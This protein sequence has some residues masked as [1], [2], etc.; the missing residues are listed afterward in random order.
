ML[1]GCLKPPIHL[2]GGKAFLSQ[3]LNGFIPGHTLYSEPFAGAAH[4]LF[5]KMPSKAEILNDSDGHLTS[6]FRVIQKP[7]KCKM[8]MERLAFMPYSRTLWQEIRTSWKQGVIP[9]D[10]VEAASEWFYL[11][12]ST[13][14]GDQKR[15]GFAV[16]SAT[17]RNPV[18]SFRNAVETFGD[19][20]VRLR[21]VCIENLDYADCISR[22]NSPDTLFYCDPPYLSAGHYYGQDFTQEDHRAL[23]RLLNEVRGKA[24]ITHYLD[25][26]YDELYQGWRRFEYSSFKGSS[27]ADGGQ[28]KPKT[29]EVLYCNFKPAG[30]T[31][32]LFPPVGM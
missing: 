13:F 11:N 15:G 6:F 25:G 26:L 7:D 22:Y 8:L 18:Q 23:A 10:P 21:N 27:K 12:R 4:L 32:S 31:L 14:S 29:V 20:T 1:S 19:V 2:M 24:M 16:P 5:G 3:W 17:G 9:V 28:E 30:R